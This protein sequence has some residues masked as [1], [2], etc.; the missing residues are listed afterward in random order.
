[1]A[2][3]MVIVCTVVLMPVSA[4]AGTDGVAKLVKSYNK[5]G[6]FSMVFD[7]TYPKPKIAPS[8]FVCRALSM[9]KKTEPVP[10]KKKPKAGWFT[11]V[12]S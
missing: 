11:A 9:W 2:L 12:C 6:K 4:M 5:D 3:L 10:G 7:L 8:T 1:V